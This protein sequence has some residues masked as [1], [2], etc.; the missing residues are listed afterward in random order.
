MKPLPIAAKVFWTIYMVVVFAMLWLL[1]APAHAVELSISPPRI[2]EKVKAGKTARGHILIKNSGVL[3]MKLS[4]QSVDVWFKDEQLQ[5]HSGEPIPGSCRERLA[6]DSLD[7]QI[8][9]GDSIRFRWM[10]RTPTTPGECRL[11]LQFTAND[12]IADNTEQAAALRL[13]AAVLVFLY[14]SHD[15]EAKPI[16]LDHNSHHITV[17]NDGNAHVRFEGMLTG[18]DRDGRK[19]FVKVSSSPIYP[20]DVRKLQLA[21]VDDGFVP[22]QVRGRLLYK[23]GKLEV[24]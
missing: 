8:P 16:M 3:P 10:I 22:V 5:I 15:G 4:S 11:A 12:V 21:P 9:P 23:G 1:L 13:N 19:G 17:R 20:G 14:V 18:V 6:I 2:I 7:V 24:E